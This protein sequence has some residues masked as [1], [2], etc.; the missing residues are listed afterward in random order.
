MFTRQSILWIGLGIFLSGSVGPAAD[1]ML[2]EQGKPRSAIVIAK[3][4]PP[5]TSF[6]AA[7][8]Q[9][10][11]KK[12]S[13]AQLSI[14][15]TDDQSEI[16]NFTGETNLILIGENAIT[17]KMGFSSGELKP[18]GFLIATEPQAL[19]IL[20]KD[21]RKTNPV[22]PG[23]SGGSDWGNAGSLYGVYQFLEELGV[24]WFFPGEIGEVI[25]VQKTILVKNLKIKRHP[26][27][28]YRFGMSTRG[29]DDLWVRRIGFGATVYPGSSAHS[30]AHWYSQYC[31]TH[32][33]WFALRRDG[34]RG[35]NLCAYAPG[36]REEMIRRA[37]K[38]L[39]R[40]D[41]AVYPDFTVLDNDGMPTCCVCEE[42]Q[43][44]ITPE[45]GVSGEMSDYW[46]QAAVELAEGIKAEFPDRRIIIGAYNKQVRPPLKIKQLPAN[47]SVG[48]AKHRLCQWSAETKKMVYSEIIAGWLKLKPAAVIFWEYYNID[49]W[50][51]G[52][53]MGVPAVAPRMISEDIK[54][55]KKLSE[56]SQIP[57][58]GEMIYYGGRYYPGTESPWLYW[59]APDYYVTAKL[60]WNPDL[61][62]ESLMEDYY[63]GLFGPAADPM[64]KF[65]SGIEEVWA[66]GKWGENFYGRKDSSSPDNRSKDFFGR[67]PWKLLFTSE[68]LK[69]M[70]GYL[71]E[72]KRLAPGS[73]YKERIQIIENGFQFTLDQAAKHQEAKVSLEELEKAHAV[74]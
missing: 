40:S 55:L 4:A 14:V 65:Y 62:V 28:V 18:D 51:R 69:K 68:I 67:N 58:L 59:I 23:K 9:L 46:A 47:V 48:I 10:Y 13:G 21:D 44:R 8:L 3:D 50:G 43:K 20:G 74:W 52:K 22:F 27:F 12:I 38:Y 73:P 34:D 2:V 25:P 57:F 29:M 24:R 60:L 36:I 72:A 32:P 61:S 11:I 49:D 35:D 63:Q 54:E 5:V 31:L 17:R 66:S 26:Y 45:E 7:E 53:W 39:K 70:A 37:K 6:A 19:I 56:K 16:R 42:C 30:F 15:A 71:M 41:P 1:L 64:K 33:E